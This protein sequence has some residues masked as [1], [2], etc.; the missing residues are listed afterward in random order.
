MARKNR[1]GNWHKGRRA[2]P[3]NSQA[4]ECGN[5]HKTTTKAQTV[6]VQIGRNHHNLD[7]KTKDTIVYG[8]DVYKRVCK[9]N[10]K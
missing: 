1:M 4:V 9:E 10:C 5:C 8:W 6:G 2:F 7:N 3:M